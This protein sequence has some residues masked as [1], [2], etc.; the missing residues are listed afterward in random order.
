MNFNQSQLQNNTYCNTF[1][2]H[3]NHLQ[4]SKSTSK[5]VNEKLK[6]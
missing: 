3:A 2:Q 6:L 1:K 5:G 4:T